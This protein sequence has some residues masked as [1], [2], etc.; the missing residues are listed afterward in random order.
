MVTL[1]P[2]SHTYLDSDNNQYQSVTRYINQFVPQFDF[3]NKSKQ[4]ASKHGMDVEEVR[5]SWRLKNKLSTDFGTLIHEQIEL[6]L[7]KKK[8]TTVDFKDTI[9]SICG[10]VESKFSGDFLLEHTVCNKEFKIAGTSDLIVDNKNTFDVVDFK[11]NKQ[12]KY[13]SEYSDKFL[14]KPI[15]HLPNSEYFKYALQLSFYAYFY[16]LQT[17]KNPLRLCFYW[18]KRKNNSYEIL[19]GSK[20]IRYNVPYLE[21]EV[22]SLINNG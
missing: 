11:T 12:I 8:L 21:E 18:L 20:W 2:I 9:N 5:E 1:E 10:E 15:S 6:K 7:S 4:Y 14:L 17:G 22:I 19:D 3:D 13:T 16:K